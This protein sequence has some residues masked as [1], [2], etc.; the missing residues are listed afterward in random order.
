MAY[1]N[2]FIKVE[3]TDTPENITQERIK[4]VKDYFK[5]KYNT[6]DVKV[7][8]T[9][10]RGDSSVKLNSAEMGNNIMDPQYQK[11]LMKDFIRET[12]TTIK[13]DLIDRL[14]NRINGELDMLDQ[15]RVKYTNWSIKKV[16][17]SN[18]LSFGDNNTI[19]FE[20]FNGITTVESTP[21]NFGGKTVSTVELLLYLFF[22]STTKT[23]TSLDV[24]NKFRDK[25]EV[26]V[27]GTLTIDGNDYVIERK[28][29]R[30]KKTS[31]SY[32]VK[33]TLDF[34]RIGDNGDVVNLEGE[35][36]RETEKLITEVIGKEED[37]LTT[38]MTT[39]YNLEQMIEYK[40]TA[41][42]QV[43]SRFLGL[44]LLKVKEEK[45]KTI[46]ND[47][48][49][50]LLS[51]TYNITTLNDENV[52]YHDNIKIEE[53]NI[54]DNSKKL[55]NSQNELKS[56]SKTRDILV[57]SKNN[58]ANQDLM[59]VNPMLLQ[60]E[61]DD[62]KEERSKYEKKREGVVVVEPE[63]Y[64]NEEDHARITERLNSLIVDERVK[65]SEITQEEQL[66]DDLKNGSVC[67]RCKRPLEGVDHTKEIESSQ[68]R[69]ITLTGELNEIKESLNAVRD[70]DCV[71]HSIKKKYSEYENNKVVWERY[72]LEIEKLDISIE[73]SQNKLNDYQRNKKWLVE[74]QRIDKEI[75]V[76]NTKMETISA[77]IRNYDV[78]I[79]RSRNEIVRLKEKIGV[80]E[81]IIKKI[82]KEEDLIFV[83]KTYLTIF[84][85]NGISKEIM[86][87][88]IP[89]INQELHRLLI[90]SCYFTLEMNI[91]E[92]NEVEFLMVDNES[93]V[94]KP[95]DSGSGY[96]KTIASLAIRSILTKVSSLPKPNIVVMDE[97]FGKVADENLELVGEFFKKIKN[98]FEHIFVISHNPLIRNWS[99]NLIMITKE[100][101]VSSIGDITRGMNG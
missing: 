41:R 33:N 28:V 87:N 80:N 76:M 62:L 58:E 36:K 26:W 84:G 30:K 53:N 67:P 24:F 86:K 65:T 75:L 48:S 3:W 92:K 95:I 20:E 89:L 85:K 39:G 2:P 98:Y 63:K 78:K 50:K 55:L 60:K 91:N 66:V 57:M 61:I 12:N 10:Y 43:L 100:E 7:I 44:E 47:W 19:N 38:I 37:F 96:E 9:I 31:G 16:E 22:G 74:N 1:E 68:K 25:D 56:I 99:D 4:R 29:I 70:E 13:W 59:K 69:V 101:N 5:S 73:K 23:K 71:Y 21:K 8:S 81:D 32:G 90:D 77:E 93:R 72:E 46:Y 64:Y 83:F 6:K 40:P 27:K 52:T 97:V 54:D 17:F 82:K 51:N 15:N 18:F 11:K 35:Q 14:D 94:V 34:Y 88:M 45:C 49:K 42:G 79:E